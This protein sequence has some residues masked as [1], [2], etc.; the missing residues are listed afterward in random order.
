MR[1]A[2]PRLW[3]LVAEHALSDLD[4]KTADLAF[5]KVRLSVVS[6]AFASVFVHA[7]ECEGLNEAKQCLI[8]RPKR[9]WSRDIFPT[10]CMI[11]VGRL[12]GSAVC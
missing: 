6:F 7:R 1:M 10:L 9:S 12:S 11:T 4:F 8:A 5:V 2:H 3:A